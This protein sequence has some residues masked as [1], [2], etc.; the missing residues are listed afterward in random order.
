MTRMSS[1][2]F[3]LTVAI[4]ISILSD[5]SMAQYYVTGR[6][7]CND[8]TSP[9]GIE[10][11]YCDVTMQSPESCAAAAATLYHQRQQWGGDYCKQCTSGVFDQYKSETGPP[12]WIQ[13]GPCQGQPY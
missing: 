8:S 7:H 12:E 10:G 4:V 9:P 13:G 2:V 5:Y 6:F 1:H 3:T 11:G